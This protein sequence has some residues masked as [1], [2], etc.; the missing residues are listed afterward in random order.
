MLDSFFTCI[1]MVW[2]HL[3]AT[4]TV[5]IYAII[6]KKIFQGVKSTAEIARNDS[7]SI[8]YLK[9]QPNPRISSLSDPSKREFKIQTDSRETEAISSRSLLIFMNLMGLGGDPMYIP[10]KIA[11]TSGV[12][13]ISYLSKHHRLR[14]ESVCNLSLYQWYLLQL[15]YSTLFV[16]NRT[17]L[18]SYFPTTPRA[19]LS[20]IKVTFSVGGSGFS[21]SGS[22]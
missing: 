7:S 18:V 16:C 21:S 17:F 15:Y 19:K 22:I 12:K 5:L 14:R 20:S 9:R 11:R 2:F 8:L 1:V 10:A 4:L 13:M 6:H 3:H